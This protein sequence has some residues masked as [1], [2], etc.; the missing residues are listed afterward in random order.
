MQS[1]YLSLRV[2]SQ[3]VAECSDFIH[4]DG[5]NPLIDLYLSTISF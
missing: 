4:N 2:R 1:G 3:S 5:I